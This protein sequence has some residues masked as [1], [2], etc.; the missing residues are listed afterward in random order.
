MDLGELIRKTR[1]LLEIPLARLTELCFQEIVEKTLVY[2]PRTELSL[3]ETSSPVQIYTG[4]GK[5]TFLKL[6]YCYLR[7]RKCPAILY[8]LREVESFQSTDADKFLP[9]ESPEVRRVLIDILKLPHALTSGKVHVANL[10]GDL[11]SASKIR[12][13]TGGKTLYIIVDDVDAVKTSLLGFE[14]AEIVDL[15]DDARVTLILAVD[16]VEPELLRYSPPLDIREV[17]QAAPRDYIE[18]WCRVV[19]GLRGSELVDVVNKLARITR[20]GTIDTPLPVLPTWLVVAYL[21]A[22]LPIAYSLGQVVVNE[23]YFD[24][25]IDVLAGR[26]E[27]AGRIIEDEIFRAAQS[28]QVRTALAEVLGVEPE[29]ISLEITSRRPGYYC[30]IAKTRGRELAIW[31]RAREGVVRESKSARLLLGLKRR[32]VPVLVIMPTML[33]FWPVLDL[34]HRRVDLT[35]LEMLALFTAWT[36]KCYVTGTPHVDANVAQALQEYYRRR[37]LPKLREAV[38][39]LFAS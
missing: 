30:F 12:D 23:T 20:I 26:Y 29:E 4:E 14:L 38:Q 27:Q 8:S 18:K 22:A 11:S 31:V 17:P 28:G 19:L 2:V 10:L 35:G 24:F 32:E 21:A 13:V 25:F 5:S 39:K 6:V 9:G 3:V 7:Y 34:E 15:L 16:M 36:G 1:D 37:V 33:R